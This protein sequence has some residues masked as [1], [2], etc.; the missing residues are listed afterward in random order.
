MLRALKGT[1]ALAPE[2]GD[3]ERAHEFATHWYGGEADI[4]LRK[5]LTEGLADSIV[6]LLAQARREARKQWDSELASACK[7]HDEMAIRREAGAAAGKDAA[8]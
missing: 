6:A 1:L 2:P 7:M 8:K 4:S 3:V 5:R